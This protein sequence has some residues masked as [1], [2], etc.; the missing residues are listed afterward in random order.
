MKPGA[1]RIS[2]L[3]ECGYSIIIS[4][5]ALISENS[6]SFN[7]SNK[8]RSKRSNGFSLRNS[9][10]LPMYVHLHDFAVSVAIATMNTKNFF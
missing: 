10:P 2:R 7:M 9:Y 4:T 3:G 8:L 6:E 5:L 1:L